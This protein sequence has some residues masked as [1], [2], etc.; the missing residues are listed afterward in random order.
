[1]QGGT[2]ATQT[3]ALALGATAVS[4]GGGALIALD[5]NRPA[6]PAG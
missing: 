4:V 2:G 5:C 6:C 1:M 3:V